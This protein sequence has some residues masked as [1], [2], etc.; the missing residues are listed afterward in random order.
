MYHVSGQPFI[1]R[2]QPIAQSMR[3]MRCSQFLQ[4]IHSTCHFRCS[5]GNCFRSAATDSPRRAS[6]SR[7]DNSPAGGVI[8]DSAG[9][10]HGTTE[11]G[12]ANDS[13][14][15]SSGPGC[16]T[17]YELSP[18]G[19]GAWAETILLSFDG[20]DGNN[21]LGN[22]AMD[23]AGNLYGATLDGGPSPD[24]CGVYGCGLVY[25]MTK[26]GS[27]NWTETVLLDLPQTVGG[28]YSV[29]AIDPAGNLYATLYSGGSGKY[30][31][32][33]QLSKSAKAPWPVNVL[34]SF[35]GGVDGGYP[36]AGPMFYK[37]GLLGTASVG[38]NTSECVQ[39]FV[40]GCG[41]VYE[42]K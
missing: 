21:P 32:V 41:V 11:V 37:D 10:L 24:M 8:F 6:H 42:I 36:G 17:V 25:E 9:N 40:S 18:N 26:S 31:V 7:D 20:T 34:Y 19:S 38:G 33:F 3:P 30:G 4:C 12:G 16:G 28:F 27:G 13:G 29:P 23:A 14:S 5:R 35:S 39:S 15:C 2:K 22:F 1:S